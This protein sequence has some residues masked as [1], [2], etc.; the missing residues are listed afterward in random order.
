M[1]QDAS[2]CIRVGEPGDFLGEIPWVLM[3]SG[4]LVEQG[5]SSIHMLAERF[6][7]NNEI[8]KC[9][10][11]PGDRVVLTT[12][13]IPTQQAK[14][15][16][17]AL[18]YVV[19][20]LVAQDIH[21]VHI[22]KARDTGKNGIYEI[23]IIKH[24]DLLHWL[25]SLFGAG[26]GPNQVVPDLLAVPKLAEWN[27]LIERE[28][29]HIRTAEHLGLTVAKSNAVESI[30]LCLDSASKK[31]LSATVQLTDK[32]VDSELAAQLESAFQEN[33]VLDVECVRYRESSSEVLLSTVAR[34]DKPV[35][36]LLQGGY[37]SNLNEK[38]RMRAL[39]IALSI[40]GSLILYFIFASGLSYWVQNATDDIRAES[41]A[42]YKS[43][44]PDEKR[45]INPKVQMAQHLAEQSSAASASFAKLLSAI[46]KAY[47]SVSGVEI[48]KLS[49]N[50]DGIAKM[51]LT[52]QTHEMI[53]EFVSLLI[54]NDVVANIQSVQQNESGVEGRLNVEVKN[55]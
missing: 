22:A 36:N 28:V 12:V 5:L 16:R 14:Y 3:R 7:K 43:I 38:K 29:V 37:K 50:D 47:T 30:K 19:E 6:G 48:Q 51:V 13:N 4:Q 21:D 34:T 10:L 45:I 18:P 32:E 40:V 8:S 24:R 39:P 46:S 33:G 9:V 42:L 49:F 20:E 54:A 23:G 41:I 55:K 17:R 31:P 35:F 44:Y 27:V 11:I 25:E 15:I 53:Q 26:L 1:R 2:L 52:S